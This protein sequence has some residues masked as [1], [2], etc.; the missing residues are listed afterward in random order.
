MP[1][2]RPNANAAL[3]EHCSKIRCP[4]VL[5][6]TWKAYKKYKAPEHDKDYEGHKVSWSP[7]T[8]PSHYIKDARSITKTSYPGYTDVPFKRAA[9]MMDPFASSM[10]SASKGASGIAARTP[11]WLT[12][13]VLRRRRVHADVEGMRDAVPA[14]RDDE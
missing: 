7:Q 11:L 10:P 13:G 4:G 3:E 12:P 1:K 2:P 9:P 6:S 8:I 5:E 14:Q